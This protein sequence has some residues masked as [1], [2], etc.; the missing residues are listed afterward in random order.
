MKTTETRQ[1]QFNKWMAEK[2]HS[3]WYA[4][5]EKMCN[6]FEKLV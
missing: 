1:E 5:N 6:A 3:Y 4:D 2:V